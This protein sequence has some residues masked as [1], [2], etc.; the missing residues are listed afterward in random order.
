M[1][2]RLWLLALFLGG[3]VLVAFEG[4]HLL[5]RSI[6]G[7]TEAALSGAFGCA[8]RADGLS[9]DWF[10]RVIVMSGVSVACP[11]AGG[12][13]PKGRGEPVPPLLTVVRLK[14]RFDPLSLLNRVIELDWLSVSGGRVVAVSREDGDNF[15]AFLARWVAGVR[16]EGFSA[17][18]TIRRIS[19]ADTDL[20]LLFPDRKMGVTLHA[21]RALLRPNLFM[22]RFRLEIPSGT[23]SGTLSGRTLVSSRLR[24][25]ASFAE[26]GVSD[27]EI[28]ASSPGG[29]LRIAG[30]VLSFDREPEAS[31]FVR[32]RLG[33]ASLGPLFP[34]PP[35]LVGTLSFRGYLHGPVNRLRVRSV[36]SA[37][38]LTVGTE[39]LS[40]IRIILALSPGQLLADPVRLTAG[41]TKITG[42]LLA[43]FSS[44]FPK[45][46]VRLRER[47]KSGLLGPFSASAS[48]R[49]PLPTR[50]EEWGKF[51]TGLGRLARVS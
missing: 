39:V 15:R 28:V 23:L 13:A 11:L 1:N 29:H 43:R 17:S 14:A 47:G 2:R 18:A 5:E 41:T 48:G 3:A 26:G 40:D 8:V 27:L 36:L 30:Q 20:S 22:N 31:L 50:L 51:L 16:P 21:V 25:T 32:G 19:F 44:P 9:I 49:L 45:A 33:L 46:D 12:V 6:A 37:P 24:A 10:R 38:F 35:A 7:R 4:T 42:R 34:T